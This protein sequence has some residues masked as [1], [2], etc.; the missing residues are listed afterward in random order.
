MKRAALGI[1]AGALAAILLGGCGGGKSQGDAAK[2]SA[3][4]TRNE[5]VY[6]VSADI[7]SMDPRNALGTVTAGVM[8]D[9]FSSLLKTDDRG[10]IVPDLAES[11]KNINDTTWEFK[12]RDGI[13]FHDGSKLTS[14]DVKYTI[15]TIRDASKSYRLASDFSFMQIELIDDLNFRI[16]TDEP[17]SGLLLRLNYVKIVPRAY[18]ERVGDAEFAAKPI[19]S[20]PYKF[21]EWRKDDRVLLE[22][23]PDYFGGKPAIDRV[24]LRVIPEAASRIAALESGEVDIIHNVATSQISRLK[25]IPGIEILSAPTSRVMFAGFNL[26]NPG[27]LQ[28]KR[29]RQALNYATDRASIVQG[30]L[31][32]YGTQIATI[33]AP[34]YAEYD[35]S[36]TPYEY[37]PA[38]AK[39]LLAAAGYPNGFPLTFSVTS[40]Y[41]N[42]QDIV[43]ALAA[44]LNEV[45]LKVTVIEEETNQQR[46]KI[47]SGTGA[48]LFFQGI[49]GPYCNTDLVAKIAFG[50]GERYSTYRNAEF[51]ALRK[52]AAA[53]I[54]TAEANKLWS[55][56]QQLIKEEAPAIFTHQQF[57]IYAYN[58]RVKNWKS[59]TDEM[60][61]ISDARF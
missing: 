40:G 18:V 15:D 22:A 23:N 5:L 1:L 58:N 56:L 61:S 8:R 47:T 17:F 43:Q 20:G 9:V 3:G 32:G 55:Q 51:D 12:L 39:E 46:E 13:T 54:D 30:V 11:Y 52:K 35:P 26:V 24:I 48:D 33:A 50:S 25:V 29:V 57:G 4:V 6:A 36:V 41:L 44:Q 16:I 34:E 7:S 37:N 14:A 42:G 31:D 28:D 19:G 45:G 2:Q 49:G 27:P 10:K 53:T 21:I 60:I 59:R 38:R